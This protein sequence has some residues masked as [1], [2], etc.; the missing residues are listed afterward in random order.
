M[1]TFAALIAVAFVAGCGADGEPVRPAMTAGATLSPTGHK[2]S[3][4]V[5]GEARLGVSWGG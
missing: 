5:S 3:I 4:S 1:R 2:T